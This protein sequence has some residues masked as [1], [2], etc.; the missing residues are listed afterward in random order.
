MEDNVEMGIYSRAEAG[1]MIRGINNFSE[2]IPGAMVA[3]VPR[4]HQCLK[5][6]L[7]LMFPEP[8][9]CSGLHGQYH[10][11]CIWNRRCFGF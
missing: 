7:S 11:G 10:V 5:A 9:C 8:P 6:R 4:F 1:S 2:R 3:Q